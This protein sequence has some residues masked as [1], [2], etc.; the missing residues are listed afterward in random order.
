MAKPV[1][2]VDEYVKTLPLSFRKVF[3]SVRKTIKSAAPK[4]EELISYRVPFYRHNGHLA[5]FFAAKNH[6]S[7]VTMSIP[8]IKKFKAELKPYKISGTTIQFRPEKPVPAAL[9]RKIIKA[10]ILENNEL[11]ASR[12]KKTGKM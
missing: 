1:K 2:T 5:A 12:L 10:R 8:V 7:F 3:E 11:A 6:C 9:I 4:A